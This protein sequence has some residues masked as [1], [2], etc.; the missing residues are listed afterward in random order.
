MQIRL[1]TRQGIRITLFIAVLVLTSF[2]CGNLPS[3]PDPVGQESSPENTATQAT[4]TG[5]FIFN[6][7]QGSKLEVYEGAVA[8]GSVIQMEVL[9]PDPL[10]WSET[11]FEPEGVQ[12]LVLLGQ[13]D[14][15]GRILMS[16]PLPE[17]QDPARHF[18]YAAWVQP[19]QGSPSLL[20]VIARDNRLTFPLAGQGRYQLVKIPTSEE[21]S[22][23][24][25]DK[26]PL[27]VPS[28]PQVTPSWC[29]PTALTNLAGYHV[30]AWPAGGLGSAWG[31][32]SNW[33]LAGL[34][35]QPPNQGNFFHRIL[36]AAGYTVPQDVYQGFMNGNATV[37]V[38]NWYAFKIS[39]FELLETPT[40]LW[41]DI[42]T[43]NQEFAQELFEAFHAYVEWN[44][45]GGPG[46]RRPV[47]WGSNLAD[48]SR[49]L[50]GSDGT[51]LYFNDPGSGSWN[52]T[53][54][55][56]DY[57]H[58]TMESLAADTTEIIGTV[59]FSA[60]PRLENERRGVLWLIQRTYD[61]SFGDG[62]IVLRQGPQSDLKVTWIWNGSA[63]YSYGYFYFEETSDL[64]FEPP[65]GTKFKAMYPEDA[66]E[67]GY[68]I[69]SI[70]NEDYVF[71]VQ[72]ELFNED[73]KVSMELPDQTDSVA[74]GQRVDFFPAGSFLLASLKSGLYHLKFS[75]YQ[76]TILQDVKY[77]FFEI[78]TPEKV[79]LPNTAV[80]ASPAFCRAGP[81]NLYSVVTGFDSG[82]ELGLVGLN[83]DS[84]WGKFEATLNS[85]TFQCWV[86]LDLVEITGEMN[87][88]ILVPPPIP[89]ATVTSNFCSQFTT[90]QT[91]AQH[92]EC[93][94][95]RLV[96][97]GVC[98]QK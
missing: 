72:S 85:I 60:Q 15:L 55:W 25:D 71:S 91:C 63:P 89:T 30:G 57:F 12:Y 43:S 10:P 90:P 65:L 32:S 56:Q 73:G 79:G 97:P 1:K 96:V 53:R 11:P 35:H 84:T 80:V 19:E 33:Y 46:Y 6:G 93:T 37:I 69:R 62:S 45:W 5:S 50:T 68:A 78:I 77:V 38:W 27:S 81:G 7:P 42:L 23:L 88:P 82:Q 4:E 75:L 52:E 61:G 66:V 2:S 8:D 14:Q 74:S 28:Y 98:R 94:W 9:P 86:S 49:T 54:S 70:S 59:T 39:D 51:L 3:V 20:G 21:L 64:P 95:D 22:K 76:G 13:G 92:N 29:S 16:V 31:E 26:E 44:V 18:H 83:P 67:Y 24:F 34:A 47:A 87:V 41:A 36:S 48:H 40:Y 58:E 17:T